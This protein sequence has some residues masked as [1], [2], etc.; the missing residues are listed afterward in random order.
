MPPQHLVIPRQ[1]TSI[2]RRPISVTSHFS[3]ASDGTKK[4]FESLKSAWEKAPEGAAKDKAWTAL[5]TY[6]AGNATRPNIA[7][8]WGISSGSAAIF[9]LPLAFLVLLLVEVP[10]RLMRH[11][12]S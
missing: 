6:A 5:E 10:Q 7:L 9:A 12:I 4:K 2:Q 8:W 11:S 1:R 3:N